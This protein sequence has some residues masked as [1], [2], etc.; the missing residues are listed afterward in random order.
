VAVHYFSDFFVLEQLQD[1]TTT[2]VMAM[3]K[4]SFVTHGIPVT[5]PTDNS[6]QV[7]SEEFKE[8]VCRWKFN[9]ITSSPYYPESNG[10]SGISRENREVTTSK[11]EEGWKRHLA[12]FI[13]MAKCSDA[14]IRLVAMSTLDV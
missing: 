5:V 13:R 7:V 4:R 14:R 11:S 2:S 9:D 3:L 1:T 8:F 12:L 10:K 6:P